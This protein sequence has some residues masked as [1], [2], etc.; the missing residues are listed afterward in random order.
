MYHDIKAKCMVAK[1]FGVEKPFFEY[2]MLPDGRVVS[3]LNNS[4]IS[5]LL[6][7]FFRSSTKVLTSGEVV[8]GKFRA[9]K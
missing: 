9:E 1:I 6:P 4:E 7:D 5:N 2:L 3:D 8:E